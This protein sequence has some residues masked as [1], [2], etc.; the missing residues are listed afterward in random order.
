[1]VKTKILITVMILLLC[2][3]GI[4]ISVKTVFLFLCCFSFDQWVYLSKYTE[5]KA[6]YSDG[7]QITIRKMLY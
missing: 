5:R 7:D 2:V 3:I 6:N 4:E 1:M